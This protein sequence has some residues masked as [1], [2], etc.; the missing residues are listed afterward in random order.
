M[1]VDPQG[2]PQSQQ[3]PMQSQQMQQMQQS[4]T[5]KPPQAS[6]GPQSGRP[7]GS[8]QVRPTQRPQQGM[9]YGIAPM[10]SDVQTSAEQYV[11]PNFQPPILDDQNLPN[12]RL[13]TNEQT[14]QTQTPITEQNSHD[15][16]IPT[17]TTTP[18]FDQSPNLDVENP[19]FDPLIAISKWPYYVLPFPIDQLPVA[20]QDAINNL[21]VNQQFFNSVNQSQGGSGQ[22][23]SSSSSQ[24][25]QG[26]SQ[27]D[28]SNP[29]N[30]MIGYIPIVFFNSPCNGGSNQGQLPYPYQQQQQ[31][32]PC[33]QCLQQQPKS[34]QL[35]GAIANARIFHNSDLNSVTQVF[36]RLVRS[37]KAKVDQ[38]I[39]GTPA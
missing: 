12:F 35:F 22:Q 32:I 19:P 25:S 20:I 18:T 26:Q 24:Q 37:R 14:F 38:T 2:K 27:T 21:Y 8:T 30:G 34:N 15:N 31:Q 1:Q 23:S 3:Q 9:Y 16:Q 17:N 36:P 6:Q 4:S 11:K 29:Q 5:S 13:S 33:S 7:Q 39:T 28:P 10:A